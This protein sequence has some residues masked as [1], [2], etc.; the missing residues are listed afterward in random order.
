V[1]VAALAAALLAVFLLVLPDIGASSTF[2]STGSI[3]QT[4]TTTTSPVDCASGT[5]TLI[6]STAF[7][8]IARN[9]AGAYMSQCK[10][11]KITVTYGNG[12]DGASGV[13]AVEK[14]AESGQAGSMIA[15]Y[16]GATTTVDKPVPLTS[17]P[18]GLVIFSVVA[19]VG[20]IPGSN[21]SL[22]ELGM[23]FARPEGVPGEV[24]VGLQAGSA[25]REALLGLW[26]ATRLGSDLGYEVPVSVRE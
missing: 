14:S 15:M 4:P 11:V 25:T 7:G 2:R 19:H 13:S 23:L 1:G 18:V 16:D 10:N 8:Q 9:A 22:A 20:V 6:G 5:L 26:Q 17:V 12:I 24:A 21:I 3:R